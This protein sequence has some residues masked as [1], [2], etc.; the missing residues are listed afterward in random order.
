MGRNIKHYNGYYNTANTSRFHNASTGYTVPSGK[1]AR[2]GFSF[3]AYGGSSSSYSCGGFYAGGS[4]ASSSNRFLVVY[5]PTT[6]GTTVQ[7]YDTHLFYNANSGHHWHHRNRDYNPRLFLMDGDV[8]ERYTTRDDLWAL[9]NFEY[10]NSPGTNYGT[11][12]AKEGVTTTFSNQIH[13]IFPDRGTDTGYRLS[14]RTYGELHA[15]AGETIYLF[16]FNNST[17][18]IN[19]RAFK[20]VSWNIFIIE[21]DA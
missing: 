1:V 15:F 14:G 19:Y 7:G 17:S 18:N 13:A 20:S 3:N 12:R 5:Y 10:P 11:L 8:C 21:E 9:Y 2:I 16:D 4:S 6:T